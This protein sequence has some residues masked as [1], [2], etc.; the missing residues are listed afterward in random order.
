MNAKSNLHIVHELLHR[1]K[2]F[3]ITFIINNAN[4]F[5][6]PILEPIDTFGTNLV[7]NSRINLLKLLIMRMKIRTHKINVDLDANSILK[8]SE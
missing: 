1:F 2:F 6:R 4:T 8:S 7:T 3:Y 5:I